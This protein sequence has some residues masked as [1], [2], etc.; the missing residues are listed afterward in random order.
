M[1]PFGRAAAILEVKSQSRGVYYFPRSSGPDVKLDL[2]RFPVYSF[3]NGTRM[4]FV[5]KSMAKADLELIRSFWKDLRPVLMPDKPTVSN[6]RLGS[7]GS[8]WGF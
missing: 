2:S 5:D 4:M 7:C 8:S 1:G 6:I 3:E